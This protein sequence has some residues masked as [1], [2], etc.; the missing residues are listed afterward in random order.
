LA[1]QPGGAAKAIEKDRRLA[2]F[3]NH[4]ALFTELVDWV[5]EREI[6]GDFAFDC[7]FTNAEILT[8]STAP[9][10]VRR[11]P[12]VQPQGLVPRHRDEGERDGQAI[13]SDDR[14]LV[15][16][17]ERKQWYFT[18]TIHMPASSTQCGS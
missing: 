6:P 9:A 15:E 17:G 14:K 12:E 10:R 1:A 2:T 11:R 7:Y 3:K 8:T 18:K 16:I 5:V 4:T 13:G